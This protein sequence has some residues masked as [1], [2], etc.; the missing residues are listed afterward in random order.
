MFKRRLGPNPHAGGQSTPGLYG[1]PDILELE[2]GDF[3]II[4]SDITP[5]AAA[6]L[7]AGVSCGPDERIVRIPRHILVNAKSDIPEKV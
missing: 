5:A 6:D 3:A 4:G 7:P 1:C 2:N